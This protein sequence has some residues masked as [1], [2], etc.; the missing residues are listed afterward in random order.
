M[1]YDPERMQLM[2]ESSFRDDELSGVRAT[3]RRNDQWSTY[4][5]LAQSEENEAD[6]KLT[7]DN[8][9]NDSMRVSTISWQ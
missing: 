1:M 5:V 6:V 9:A 7:R 4:N 8:L 2:T 3:D